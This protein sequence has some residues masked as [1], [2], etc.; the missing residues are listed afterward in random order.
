[1]DCLAGYRDVQALLAPPLLRQDEGQ[2]EHR[3]DDRG[4][5]D[6]ARSKRT[7]SYEDAFW[8]EVFAWRWRKSTSVRS[9]SAKLAPPS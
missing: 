3:E 5:G 8:A 7:E 9:T 1:M 4:E 6:R 2:R